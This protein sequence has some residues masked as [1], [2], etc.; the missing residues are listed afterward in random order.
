MRSSGNHCARLVKADGNDIP[1]VTMHLKP[2]ADAEADADAQ[3]QTKISR[4]E[5][6]QFE[7]ATPEL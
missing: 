1:S 3:S 5:V 2:E 7:R 6:K 4:L